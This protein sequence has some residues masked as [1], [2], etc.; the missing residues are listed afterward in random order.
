V[1]TLLLAHLRAMRPVWPKAEFDVAAEIAEVENS[2][3]PTV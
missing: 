2:L 1:A 3:S